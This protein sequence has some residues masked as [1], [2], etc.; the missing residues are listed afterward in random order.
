MD[1]P[2]Q[3]RR[4]ATEWASVGQVIE[5]AEK[6]S[7][8]SGLAAIVEGDLAALETDKMP[9]NWRERIVAGQ[10]EFGFAD[11]EKRVPTVTG[12]ATVEVDAVCQRC[13]QPFLLPLRIEPRLILLEL[14][15]TAAG[16]EDFEVWELDQKTLR[17][18]DFVE[19]LLIMAMPFAAKHDNMA[20]C[21]AFSKTEENVEEMKTPF[22]ALRLQMQQNEKDPDW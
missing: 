6:I 21:K 2:L 11:I 10:L 9:A 17:P 13:L 18:Q 4:T 22:A 3:D 20:N 14:E 8:F 7:S 15:E 1:N 16:Y 5:I 19:E 12:S